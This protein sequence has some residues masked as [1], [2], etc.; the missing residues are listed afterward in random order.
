MAAVTSPD[1][2]PPVDAIIHISTSDKDI[3]AYIRIEPPK[4]GGAAPTFGMMQAALSI[5][6]ISH[7]INMEKLKEIEAAPVYNSDILVAS[8]VAPV[9]GV[10]GTASFRIKTEKDSP[11][12][13]KKKTV[14]WFLRP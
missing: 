5:Y 6:G 10:D 8:G 11:R 9:D 4:N 2:P 3:E 14:R 1:A 7:N 13:K 12:P